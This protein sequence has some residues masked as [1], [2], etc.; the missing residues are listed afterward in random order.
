MQWAH[1]RFPQRL[2]SS[3]LDEVDVQKK[4]DQCEI[5]VKYQM[6]H[7]LAILG[8]GLAPA[9]QTRRTWKVAC[10]LFLVGMTLFSGGLYSMVFFSA[11]GHWSIVPTRGGD[12]DACLAD[13]CNGNSFSRQI[14]A[15]YWQKRAPKSNTKEML[16]EAAAFLMLRLEAT[17]TILRVRDSMRLKNWFSRSFA[18][19]DICDGLVPF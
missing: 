15:W 8:L 17:A 2:R 7:S 11:M 12:D 16:M 1:T 9:T 13:R 5:A 19:V 18:K 4:V 14:H 3:G 10:V 6:Y